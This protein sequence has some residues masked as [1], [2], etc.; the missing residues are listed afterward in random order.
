[1]KFYKDYEQWLIG[2]TKF[3]VIIYTLITINEQM[4]YMGLLSKGYVVFALA[5]IGTLLPGQQLVVI[6]MC[7]ISAHLITFNSIIGGL[8]VFAFLCIYFGFIR[9]YPKESMLMVLVMVG[10]KLHIH[11]ILTLVVALFAGVGGLFAIILGLV[12]AWA[13]EPFQL[14]LRNAASGGTALDTI[15]NVVKILT[16]KTVL[17]S[18]MLAS[19]VVCAGVFCIVYSIRKQPIEY[20]PYIAIV[21]GGCMNLLGFI[22]AEL[23]LG[24]ATNIGQTILWTIVAVCI[25]VM[26]QL[27]IKPMHYARTE[28][29]EY[30]DDE[31]Y[32]YVKIVPKIKF[33]L[34][35]RKVEEI[36]T[37]NDKEEKELF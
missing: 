4:G 35:D 13:I 22:M 37:A 18:G 33:D 17:D 6:F 31:N 5:L 1:M 34:E 32:Y 19:V 11:Y 25:A 7:S 27:L 9:F 8:T 12:G 15:E 3:V 16:N 23:F 2:M 29:V 24:I 20:A 26:I 21:L 10:F 28:S 14:I 36:Y 30:E